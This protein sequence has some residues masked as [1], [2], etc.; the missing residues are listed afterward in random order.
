MTSQY[1]QQAPYPY[2]PAPAPQA[3][4]GLAIASLI[5]GILWLGWLGSILAVIFGHIALRRTRRNAT[6]GSGLAIAG[7]VLGWIGVGTLILW[8]ILLAAAAGGSGS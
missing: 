4:D 6:A 5:L 1:P 8:I 3:T 2:Q 7:L